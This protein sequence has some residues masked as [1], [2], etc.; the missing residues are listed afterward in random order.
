MSCPH[1]ARWTCVSCL[2]G[3]WRRQ[4]AAYW[5]RDAAGNFV[6]AGR[7]VTLAEYIKDCTQAAYVAGLEEGRKLGR[8]P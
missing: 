5:I 3:M 8:F 6:R 1:D 4:D 7:P 2:D